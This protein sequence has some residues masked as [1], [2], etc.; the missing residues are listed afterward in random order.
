MRPDHRGGRGSKSCVA[1][2]CKVQTLLENVL[3]SVLN[4]HPGVFSAKMQLVSTIVIA[5]IC[6]KIKLAAAL[7]NIT[8]KADSN[9]KFCPYWN[10]LQPLHL[11]MKLK[12]LIHLRSNAKEYLDMEYRVSAAN[13][14]QSFAIL[15]SSFMFHPMFEMCV[16]SVCIFWSVSRAPACGL[17]VFINVRNVLVWHYQTRSDTGPWVHT[18]Y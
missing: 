10:G 6:N 3:I 7:H 5:Y 14:V 13:S 11:W 15:F 2:L 9:N 4:S 12:V 8:V 1:R 18:S 16:W 17:D